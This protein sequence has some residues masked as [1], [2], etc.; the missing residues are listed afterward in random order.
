MH[1][2]IHIYTVSIALLEDP[3]RSTKL[4]ELVFCDLIN[5][6]KI[7]H[8]TVY[9]IKQNTTPGWE[10]PSGAGNGQAKVLETEYPN[11]AHMVNA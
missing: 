5:E 4:R 7:L 3:D 1:I 6:N 8:K 11:S 2:Q 10:E 9:L